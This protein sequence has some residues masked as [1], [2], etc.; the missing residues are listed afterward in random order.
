M[1]NLDT[2]PNEVI[3]VMGGSAAGKNTFIKNVVRDDSLA[4]QLHMGAVVRV[5]CPAS[6]EYIAQSPEDAIVKKREKI[7]D[8]VP[9]L[10]K[11]AG[12][13]LVKWQFVD[14][15]ARRL[16]RLQDVLPE[17]IIHKAVVLC[18]PSAEQ[19]KRLE[20]KPWWEAYGQPDW[21]ELEMGAVV[22]AINELPESFAVQYF[23]SGNDEHY[24]PYTLDQLTD[25]GR[26][27]SAAVSGTNPGATGEG[28]QY[29]RVA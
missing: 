13:V 1:I 14:T 27:N 29:V 5:V 4:E 9:N 18:P 3:W 12:V 26:W 16:E 28:I 6:M 21:I 8:Q 25:D 19:K 17:D 20:T 15:T 7:V 2:T 24:K 10:L 22:R 23:G 11:E